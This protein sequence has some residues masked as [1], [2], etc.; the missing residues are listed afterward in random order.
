MPKKSAKMEKNGKQKT[1]SPLGKTIFSH[2]LKNALD[3]GTPQL[4]SV[5]GKVLAAYP[6]LKK[7]IPAAK[8]QIGQAFKD[9]AKLTKEQQKQKLLEIAPELLEER[10]TVEEKKLVLPNAQPGKVIMRFA[11]SPS[12]ALHLGHAYVLGLN[13]ELCRQYKG[14]LI[15][16]IEDTNPENIYPQAY[17]LI[18]QDA[19]WL[20][21]GNVADVIIQS[22]RLGYYYDHA[23]KLIEKEAAYMCTCNPDAFKTLLTK[24]KAC[25]C[26]SL[27]KKENHLRWERM[28]G[29][30]KPGEA[31]LRLKTSL[32]DPNP[33]FRDFALVRIND[34]KH[35][36]VG[37]KHRVW[38]L[39]NFAVAIDDHLLDV[40]HTL[41]GK[42][43]RD[44][45]KRQKLIADYFRWDVPAA[46]YVGRINFKDL[47]L[48]ASETR[49]L[50]E[51]GKYTGWDDIRLPFLPAL[52]RRGYQPE[53]FI[54]YACEVGI[55]ETD[56]LVGKE[57]FYKAINSFNK[58]ALDPQANRYF[59]VA[60]PVK[61]IIANAPKQTVKLELHPDY[62]ARGHREFITGEEFF[63]AK[64]D[65]QQLGEGRIHRL[66]D[67]LNFTR[68]KGK[69][70]FH[71]QD[72]AAFKNAPERGAIIH[73]LPAE[74]KTVNVS[75]AMEEG[76][77]VEGIGE[78]KLL[79][80]H[81]GAIVQL[82][83]VCFAR[84]DKKEGNKLAFWAAHK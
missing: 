72:Y 48:S 78:H 62:H 6:E 66:M 68:Q 80:L 14:K 46:L 3:F 76:S 22:D 73:W 13:S 70:A 39:M 38:P 74:E 52:R 56:K 4:G 28:F 43:H 12:G 10:K 1:L 32:N 11:P 25:P 71:S 42:D 81:E 69:F 24:K 34:A 20:T 40:T 79:Q 5:L 26:R 54:R 8:A 16:R 77:I 18:E 82:E 23:E 84:L 61:V 30:Y 83:R 55:T 33:A 45:E 50:I 51:R 27:P 36:R 41:R 60:E 64:K 29:V 67:C 65:L 15:L 19:Q 57:D 53:A 49:Q 7:D 37:T 47:A 17:A 21:K 9:A 35:P 44:N 58:D 75:L 31:V 2:T 63:I 59:F